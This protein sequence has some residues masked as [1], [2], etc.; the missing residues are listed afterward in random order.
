M[1]LLTK[2]AKAKGGAGSADGSGGPLKDKNNALEQQTTK[3]TRAAKKYLLTACISSRINPK[4][5][6]KAVEDD[7]RRVM[8]HLINTNPDVLEHVDE[9]GRTLLHQCI[10][11][12]YKFGL[13]YSNVAVELISRGSSLKTKDDE[14]KTV[15][16]D[17]VEKQQHLLL[18]QMIE[19]YKDYEIKEGR[20]QAVVGLLPKEEAKDSTIITNFK[21]YKLEA[22]E[23]KWNVI[24]E[25]CQAYL[26]IV[27]PTRLQ[28][29]DAE[30]KVW[31]NTTLDDVKQLVIR[32]GTRV[33]MQI[34]L[35]NDNDRQCYLLN[36]KSDYDA[37]HFSSIYFGIAQRRN[38]VV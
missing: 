7:E 1:R 4:K 23:N 34:D 30:K 16:Q 10:E 29:V 25:G 9:H 17:A 24:G 33:V 12:C 37:Y 27:G 28:V 18:G 6:V 21:M 15:M 13:E 26:S 3:N 22:A 5:I 2:K 14:G 11:N 19:S 35:G 8:A 31:L 32:K 20:S 36:F 38:I